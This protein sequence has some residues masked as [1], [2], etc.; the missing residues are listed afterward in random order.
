MQ[1]EREGQG[2]GVLET[3]A[4]Q[5]ALSDPEPPSLGALATP[6]GT[7]DVKTRDTA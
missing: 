6:E 2:E 5:G 1:I 3:G 7:D 4:M